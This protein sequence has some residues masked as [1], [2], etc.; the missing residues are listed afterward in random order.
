V[1]TDILPRNF[2]LNWIEKYDLYELFKIKQT[3]YPKSS[4]NFGMEWWLYTSLSF[5]TYL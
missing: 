5:Q 2:E 1:D 3:K 4:K